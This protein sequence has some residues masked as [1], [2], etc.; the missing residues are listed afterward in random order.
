MQHNLEQAEHFVA[1]TKPEVEPDLR[2]RVE[3]RTLSEKR[4]SQIRLA[5]RIASVLLLVGSLTAA[6]FT[7]IDVWECFL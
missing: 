4:Q 7:W 5:L 3:F 2:P 6:A 1:E